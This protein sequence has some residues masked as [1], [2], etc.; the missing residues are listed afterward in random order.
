[1]IAEVARFGD[2]EQRDHVAWGWLAERQ[3]AEAAREILTAAEEMSPLLRGVAVG[4][5]QRFGEEALPAWRELTEAPRV[6]PHAR[7]VLAAWDQGPEPADADWDWLAVEA[8][9][10]ALQDK[11]PDEALSRVW[12]SMPGTDLDTCLAEVRATGHPDAAELSQEVAEFAAS[13][14]PR[15]IDQVA[16][17]KVSL[18]GS[19]PPIWRRVRLP[20]TA[21]LG[22]LHDVI[23]VLFGW[24]G[25]HLHVFQAGK[26]HYSDPL[27]DLDETRNEEAILLGDAMARNAGKISYTY[28]LGTCWEHEIALEQTL[29][30]D[31]GQDYAVCVAYTGGSPVEYWPSATTPKNPSRSTWPRSTA[32]WPRSAERRSEVAPRAMNHGG[33][34]PSLAS[35]IERSAEL[36][37]ALVD[38]ALSPRFE[39]HLEQF[40]LEAAGPDQ[41]L[42]E[43]EA[44]GVID[45]FA[46]QHRLPN[47]K[48]MLDQFLASWP[49]LSAADREMLRGW[50]DPVEGIFETRG[51]DRDSLVLLNLLDDLE[52]RVYSNMG[53]AAFRPL[54]KGGFLHVRLVPI[55]PVPGAWLVSGSMSAYRK[56]D[57][58]QI[59]QAALVVATKQPEL[60]YRN[61]EKIE[62]AWAQMREDRAA[63]VE[64]F[65]GDELVLPPGEA[66]ERLNA[67]YRHQQ[68][69]ALARQPARRRPRN[70]PGVDA[71]AFEFPPEL[72]DAEHH[73]HHLRRDRRA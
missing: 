19:R 65:G 10:A 70:L 1:M 31:R 14:A 23:Q 33:G 9:A 43:G 47:G 11:G 54:P 40:M 2:E 69:A 7:A 36:K 66:E 52:Y 48:T 25:D 13:G 34:E 16:E 5:V 68:E 57:A 50:R 27:M 39:R 56:S 30:R 8:A 38:F 71:P 67:Y 44:I 24:D 18:S 22:D 64:F 15:S 29:P 60:V 51:K 45:R 32:S 63:F 20:V 73:R 72:A 3:P 46:L 28:D 35:L 58:A 53:P 41:V 6:G 61:P 17:L 12:E 59:A 21:T 55:C 49:D 26:K 62:Q 42:S 4:V 37:R